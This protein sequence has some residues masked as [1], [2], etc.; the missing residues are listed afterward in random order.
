M[1]ATAPRRRFASAGAALALGF[2]GCP[3][4]GSTPIPSDQAARSAVEA[5]LAAW[6]AGKPPGPI[7]GTTPPVQAV[8]TSWQNG[9]KLAAFEVVGPVAGASEK[10]YAVRLTPAGPDAKIQDAEYVVLGTDPLFVYRDADYLR[11]LN[12]DDNPAPAKPRR[13]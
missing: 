7:E 9:Q 6:K 12:M 4:G 3:G 11:T 1:I 2:A 13:R 10:R 8:D 5:A